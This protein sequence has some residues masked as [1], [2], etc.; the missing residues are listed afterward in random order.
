MYINVLPGIYIM[1]CN[2]RTFVFLNIESM[3]VSIKSSMPQNRIEWFEL[4]RITMMS[5][6]YV[7]S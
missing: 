4:Q 6:S 1:A 5:A 2:R 7:E 3:Y